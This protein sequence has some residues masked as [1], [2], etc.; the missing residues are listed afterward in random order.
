LYCGLFFL[1]LGHKAQNLHHITVKIWSE[2]G[3]TCAKK[4]QNLC[5][6]AA[7]VC[8]V[9]SNLFCSAHQ[10]NSICTSKIA[11]IHTF[12]GFGKFSELLAHFLGGML[13]S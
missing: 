13:L 10:K 6:K 4:W 2:D 7:K 1:V 12:L 9:C 5:H 8:T 3:K 11:I